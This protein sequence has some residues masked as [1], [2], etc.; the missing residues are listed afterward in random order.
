MKTSTA[1]ALCVLVMVAVL[2]Y[3]AMSYS[4]LPDRI[5][6]HWNAAGKIDGYGSKSIIFMYPSMP[7][8]AVIMLVT[9]PW[10]SPAKF[11]IDEFRGAFNY[12]M[13]IISCMMGYI[14]FVAMYGTRNPH[15]EINK[16]LI[17]GILLF[18]GLLGNMLGKV[19]RN[20]F[21]GVRTPW[22]LASDKV[23]VAT[24]RL[25]AR[26]ITVSG[27]LG[28]VAIWLGGPM[29]VIFTIVIALVLYPAVYSL[30][31]YKRLER[32]QAL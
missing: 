27:L 10:L 21:I 24:H 31:L 30:I 18:F 29:W 22:T 5:P 26:L 6:I 20:F 2:V 32:T 7:L 19:K 23:W 17:S 1:L 16:L 4:S 14:G 9:L 15:F 28:A 11:K 8:V 13:V 25:A 12:M 3:A